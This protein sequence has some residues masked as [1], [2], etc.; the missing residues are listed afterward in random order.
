MNDLP[1]ADANIQTTMLEV[2]SECITGGVLVYDKND[3][4][5]FGSQQLL[6]LL[7]ITPAAIA[8]GTRLRDFMGAVYDGGG[9][10]LCDGP[11]QRR[12][13]GREDWIA[14]QIASF[15]KERV[16]TVERRGTDRW[17][18]F[19]KRRLAS[20]FGMCLVKDISEHKKRE[21]QWRFDME[22]VQVTEE[23]LDNLPF[24][25]SVR[26]SKL[27]YVAV[28]K[29]AARFHDLPVEAF[30]GRTGADVHPPEVEKRLDPINREV[31]ETGEPK[32][33]PELVTRPNG[34]QMAIIAHKYR[35]G[36]PGRYYLVTAMED[37][38]DLVDASEDGNTVTSRVRLQALTLTNLMRRHNH[39]AGTSTD[40]EPLPSLVD[41]RILVVS[42]DLRRSTEALDVVAA[43]GAESVSVRSLAELQLFLKFA[44]EAGLAID[45]LVIDAAMDS[46][47]FEFARQ[48][49]IK[50]IE[51]EAFE[52]KQDFA[53]RLARCLSDP[54]IEAEKVVQDDW[55]ITVVGSDKPQLDILVA[56]DNEV[57]QIVFSQILEGLGYSH[58]IAADGEEAVRVWTERSPRLILMDVTLPKLNG[59]EASLK[60]R[61][62]ETPDNSIPIIGVLPLAFD[63]DRDQCIASGMNDVILKPIS[64]EALEN[65][66]KTHLDVSPRQKQA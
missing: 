64:P 28:N 2:I 50:A 13:L 38:T 4:I 55:Q 60:I 34:S 7:P 46:L 44:E 30:L 15:W 27:A 59:Y 22:R 36:K 11:N 16:D 8:R 26:D 56:E 12:V 66:F 33:L 39:A 42:A 1:S 32:Q 10:F 24:P 25:V 20:G 6:S 40:V 63:R 54:S 62:L 5:L 37:I 47:C 23:V 65:L 41:K 52:L 9:R 29:M 45:L 18:S 3:L 21:E 19:S 43:M 35:I 48:S 53:Y 61:S 17:L 58:V 31:L 14:E 57:N 51:I 49:G